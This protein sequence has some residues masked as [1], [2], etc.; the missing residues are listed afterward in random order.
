[1]VEDNYKR[2]PDLQSVMAHAELHVHRK[3]K[4][5]KKSAEMHLMCLKC[6]LKMILNVFE[7]HFLDI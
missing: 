2:W 6:F 1:M 7:K 4:C 3:N 5:F